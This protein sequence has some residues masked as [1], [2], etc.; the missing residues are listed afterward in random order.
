MHQ[1]LPNKS[2]VYLDLR[3]VGPLSQSLHS[4]ALVRCIEQRWT[5]THTEARRVS[6][7]AAQ[8]GCL[9]DQGPESV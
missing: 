1:L 7:V 5:H 2:T 4:Q 3:R 8:Y 6:L 9:H